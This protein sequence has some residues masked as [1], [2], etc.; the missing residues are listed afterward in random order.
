MKKRN[1]L[2]IG[3]GVCVIVISILG[4]LFLVEVGKIVIEEQEQTTSKE[5]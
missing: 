5:V 3:I 1:F 2:L 4:Y